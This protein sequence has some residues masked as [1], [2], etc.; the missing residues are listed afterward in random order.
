MVF[1]TSNLT[2]YLFKHMK[3][4]HSTTTCYIFIIFYLCISRKTKIKRIRLDHTNC[5]K[6]K[7][8]YTLPTVLACLLVRRVFSIFLSERNVTQL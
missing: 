8:N 3:V 6:M 2:I 5:Y 4:V 1:L 7:R